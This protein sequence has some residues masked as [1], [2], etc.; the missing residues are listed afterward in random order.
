M[1]LGK[2]SERERME[3]D[4]LAFVDDGSLFMVSLFFVMCWLSL[5]LW[6]LDAFGYLQHCCC[7]H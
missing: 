5:V 4:L 6:C 7:G 1:I 3:K 2:K